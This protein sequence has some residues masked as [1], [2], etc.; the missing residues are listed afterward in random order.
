MPGMPIRIWFSQAE[1]S[2]S[3][4]PPRI[5]EILP[6]ATQVDWASTP[7]PSTPPTAVPRADPGQ[8]SS[9]NTAWF[10]NEHMQQTPAQ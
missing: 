10:F 1:A 8:Q 4:T 3:N 9:L 5:E 2:A 6:E 7:V